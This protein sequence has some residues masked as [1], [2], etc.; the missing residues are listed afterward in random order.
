ME[1]EGRKVTTAQVPTAAGGGP[2]E[3]PAGSARGP[4][5]RFLLVHEI[6]EYPGAGG[7]A[8]YLAVAVLATIVLYYTYYTQTGVTPTILRSY[9][10]SFTFYVWI[11][12]ISNLLG[13]FAS[14][15]AGKTDKLGRANVII[16]GLLVVGLL[17][18]FGVPNAGSEWSFAVVISAIG[19]VEGAILV[20][21]PAMVR[22]YSPQLGRASAMG[23]WTIGPVAGSL[24]TSVVANRTLSHFVDW[25]SQFYI[26]GITALVTFALC[27]VFMKD[28]SAR[29]RDQLM[30]SARDHALVEA[31]AR[32]LSDQEVAAAIDHPWRQI[33]KWDLVGSSFGI[34]VFLLIYYVAAAFFTIYYSVIFVNSDGT[35]FST[36]QVNGLNFW[37]WGA[38]IVA[39]VV[40]G[41][42]SDRLRVRKP[43]MLAGAVGAI[44]TLIVFLGYATHPHTSFTTLVLTSVILA[45]FLSLAYAPWMASYTETVEAKN[46]ALV[47]TGLALWGWILRLVVG[48]SFIFLP[49]VITSV[50]TVVDNYP[51]A[52]H[53]IHGV[54]MEDWVATHPRVVDFAKAHTALLTKIAPYS[55]TL[56]TVAKTLTPKLLAKLEHALGPTFTQVLKLQK[57]LTRYVEP[58]TAQLDYLAAHKV[59]FEQLTK[60]KAKSPTQW[61]RWFWI[62]LAGMVVF[63]PTIWL[64]R[65][66]WSPARARKDEQEHEE[67]VAAELARLAPQGAGPVT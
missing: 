38:D 65:G 52:T 51:E 25:Q 9:H 32:G 36:S 16:Y 53:V 61:Q 23:F 29:L 10:M 3:K 44:V 13:A 20:A 64:A 8:G 60:G 56:A 19:L 18:T 34:A 31:R 40:V 1:G 24:I 46:P 4:L 30:V 26:S 33:A 27:L 62:D 57:T 43:L 59:A 47:G 55:A 5:F 21:T 12:I 6:D 54:S 17:I 14:L 48:I 15:P 50:S 37:F 41:A 66:R 28:L 49:I 22:D 35:P 11:V 45:V 7:R 63:I 2:G 58:N 39:L 67:A 42:L